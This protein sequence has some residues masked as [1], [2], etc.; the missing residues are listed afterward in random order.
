MKYKVG[1]RV[2]LTAIGI[3]AFKDARFFGEIG[4]IIEALD[5]VYAYPYHVEFPSQTVLM[6]ENEIQPI[7]TNIKWL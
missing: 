5:R 1:Q 2:K 4:V 7:S 6:I 3:Q